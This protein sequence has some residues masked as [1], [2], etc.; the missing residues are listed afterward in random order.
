MGKEVIPEKTDRFVVYLPKSVVRKLEKVAKGHPE[1]WIT[2]MVT[3]LLMG[4]SS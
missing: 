1:K 3:K 2:D 4:A